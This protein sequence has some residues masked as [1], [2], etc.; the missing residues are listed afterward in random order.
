M[1]LCSAGHISLCAAVLQ[2]VPRSRL[3]IIRALMARTDNNPAARLLI[4]HSPARSHKIITG[5]GWGQHFKQGWSNTAA[6][7]ASIG[8]APGDS[9]L[10]DI[11]FLRIGLLMSSNQK[12]QAIFDPFKNW[13]HL[14]AKVVSCVL[15]ALICSVRFSQLLN[16]KLIELFPPQ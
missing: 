12:D 15:M 1:K 8:I 2:I 13:I 10:P 6:L 14:G 7:T 3:T 11:M 5:L 16:F 9:E 4:N